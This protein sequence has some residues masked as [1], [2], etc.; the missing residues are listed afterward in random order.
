VSPRNIKRCNPKY[1][2]MR[3]TFIDLFAGIGGTRLGFEGAGGFCVFSSEI[4]KFARLTYF[5]NFNE[6]PHGDIRQIQ[7]HEIPDHDILL[8]G[9]PCQPFSL[10]GV[11]KRNSLNIPHGF[12]RARNETHQPPTNKPPK[13][14]RAA[15]SS[16]IISKRQQLTTRGMESCQILTTNI[17]KRRLKMK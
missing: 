8:A 9:F 1:N 10:S 16:H 4:D 14:A 15:R 6:E 3:F 11:S 7:T 12:A 17:M 5:T 2:I 13:H